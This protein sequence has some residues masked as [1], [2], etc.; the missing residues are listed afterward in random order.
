LI[1][2]EKKRLF[3]NYISHVRF[4]YITYKDDDDFVS[5]CK[6][7]DA[8]V[9]AEEEV[10]LLLASSSSSRSFPTRRRRGRSREKRRVVIEFSRFS[11]MS[12]R[13]TRGVSEN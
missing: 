8:A 3:A 5:F 4:F 11:E 1:L 9:V 2:Q 6:G 13:P 10:Q 12:I 7:S